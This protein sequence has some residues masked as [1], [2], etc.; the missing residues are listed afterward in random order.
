MNAAR[1]KLRVA[2]A[3]PD[4]PRI[5]KAFSAGSLSYSKVRAMTRVATPENEA[6]LLDFATYGT[7]HHVEKL[8][9]KTRRAQRLQAEETVEAVYAGRE[10]TYRYDENGAL[11]LRGRFPA[12]QGAVIVRALEKAMDS[13]DV[14]AETSQLADARDVTAEP[15]QR[16]G[17]GDVP[18]EPSQLDG[19]SEVSAETPRRPSVAARRADALAEVAE[20]FLSSSGPSGTTADRYQVVVH[21]AAE[22]VGAASPPRFRQS[23]PEAAPTALVG[24]AS[25]PRSGVT[26]ETSPFDVTAETPHLHDGPCVTAET[27]RRIAC[28]CSLLPVLENRFGEPLSIGR[29]TRSIPPAIR[30]ALQ[31]RDGGCRFPGCTH[32]RFVDGHHIRHWADGGETSLENLVLLCRTHHRLVHEGGYGVERNTGGEI[33]F[34]DTGRR[35]LAAGMPLPGFAE[36]LYAWIDRQV[37]EGGID[38]DGCRAK[39]D[40]TDRVDWDLA[41]AP[42][43]SQEFGLGEIRAQS[44]Q[45]W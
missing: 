13:I 19:A 22:P 25:S 35:S 24:A 34:T 10:L 6:Y 3:L 33:V 30:R 37:F 9:A 36:D 16:D 43:F 2:N 5:Q 17:A 32:T 21:V 28:D 39:L 29:K 12:E 15:S 27:S 23:R 4:L 41:A 42:I 7:A 45:R 18:A 44:A 26:A 38:N 8:V 1:E 14:T 31:L 11:V 40:A 20:T